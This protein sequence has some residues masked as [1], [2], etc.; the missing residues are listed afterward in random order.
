VSV[1]KS[2]RKPK[3]PAFQFYPA[4]YLS[5]RTIRRLTL[6]QRGAWLELIC[7]EWLDGPLENDPAELASIVGVSA[8][9][10]ARLWPGLDRCFELENGKLLN[11]R[12]ERER[13]A[14]A[15]NRE[16]WQKLGQSG[17]DKQRALRDS[18]GGGSEG[19]DGRVDTPVR[20]AHGTPT[21]PRSERSSSP[22][23]STPQETPEE[24]TA[25]APRAREPKPGA[26]GPRRI[27]PAD[28]G[29]PPIDPEPASELSKR[30]REQLALHPTL[31]VPQVRDALLRFENHLRGIPN[32]LEQWRPSR[33]AA[34]L[35]TWETWGVE[36]TVAA[37]DIAIRTGVKTPFEPTHGG[38]RSTLGSNSATTPATSMRAV[39]EAHERAAAM[40]RDVDGRRTG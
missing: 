27:E 39:I 21:G 26:S 29:P 18:D 7:S 16:R 25:C 23:S 19:L 17:N 6:E 38:P 5:S 2:G 14:Q 37:V 34:N 15:A 3:S 12:L 20:D 13:E 24:H 9:E 1:G 33:W 28:P 32:A 36:R 40:V 8:K 22:L 31:D 30:A 4:D 10:F 35:A 11:P